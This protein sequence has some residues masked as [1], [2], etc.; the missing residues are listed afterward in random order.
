M[1]SLTQPF[2]RAVASLVAEH[3]VTDVLAHFLAEALDALGGSAAGLLLRMGSGELEVLTATSHRV[4]DLEAYQAQQDTGPC[5]EAVSTQA[6][7]FHSGAD[8]MAARWPELA[9]HLAAADIAAVQ[10]HPLRWHGEVLGAVNFFYAEPVNESEDRMVTGQAFADMAT[11]ILLTPQHIAA[12]DLAART[13][14]A[15]EARTMVERAKGVLA[16]QNG[17]SVDRAY[18]LLMTLSGT[19]GLTLSAAAENVVRQASRTP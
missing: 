7:V 14:E 18:E 17:V 15:L 16:Y 12:P 8:S 4:Q 19:D 6:F 2:T 3:D 13:R 11:L 5:A 1:T 9:N 10:A